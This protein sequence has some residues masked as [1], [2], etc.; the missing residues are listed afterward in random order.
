MSWAEVSSLA[1]GMVFVLK[2]LFKL[3]EVAKGILSPLKE[4]R[5]PCRS[6]CT[7]CLLWF[8]MQ[9]SH[10]IHG[11]TAVIAPPPQLKF[12][13]KLKQTCC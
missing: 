5:W 9:V 13:N 1:D 8:L 7:Y 4:Y 6:N 2:P 12:I 3:F 11:L 10:Q